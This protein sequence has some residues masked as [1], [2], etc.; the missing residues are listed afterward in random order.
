MYLVTTAALTLRGSWKLTVSDVLLVTMRQALAGT[1]GAPSTEG[2]SSAS[3]IPFKNISASSWDSGS[4]HFGDRG[5]QSQLAIPWGL[6]VC[7][8]VRVPEACLRGGCSMSCSITLHF[9]PLKQGLSLNLD[10]GWQSESPVILLP[11]P[12]SDTVLELW[13]DHDWIFT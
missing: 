13:C 9:I 4:T 10:L 7:V 12:Y 3:Q 2:K 1:S 6:C 5:L 11:A 8:S